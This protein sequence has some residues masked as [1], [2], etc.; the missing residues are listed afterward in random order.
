MEVVECVIKRKS[1]RH[2][3]EK[4]IEEKL[5]CEILNAGIAAPSTLNLHG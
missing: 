2:F 1:I 4:E 5:L 3:R